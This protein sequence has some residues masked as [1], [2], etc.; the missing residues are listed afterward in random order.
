MLYVERDENGK[1]V[2]I[3]HACD[4]KAAEKKSMIDEEVLDFLD[5][6]VNMDPFMQLL[7]L[8]DIGI[9][10]ILEDLIDLLIKKNIF[11]LT[12]LPQ[13]AQEKINERKH[14]RQKMSDQCFMVDDIL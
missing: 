4:A 8:S 3:R 2:A 12:E 11:M 13:E 7:S 10:R 1:I 9:I 14:V 6:N 5:K